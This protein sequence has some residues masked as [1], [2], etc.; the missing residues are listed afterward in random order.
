MMWSQDEFIRAYKFAAEAHNGQKL[1]GSELPY[2]VHPCL[3]S[4]EILAALR[5]EPGH[6]EDLAVLAALLH[7][8]LE[9]TAV[10]F[11]ALQAAFGEPVAR[12]VLALSKDKALPKTLQMADSLKRIRQQPVEIWMVKLADRI[13]N[14]APPP[15]YWT[16]EKIAQYQAEARQILE[17]LG[18]AS[19]FLAERLR[20][21]IVA[22]EAYKK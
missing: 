19:D 3:V 22:Y 18:S 16:A 17:A 21:R 8:V 11:D 14:L 4:M 20:Q 1:P 5:A 6:D 9:D 13:T 7:D 15:F 2:S 12:G 10:P